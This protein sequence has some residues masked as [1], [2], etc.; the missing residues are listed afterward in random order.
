MEKDIGKITKNEITDIVIRVDNFAG[1]AGITI[2]EFAH[3]DRYTGFTKNGTKIPVDCFNEFK[4]MINSITSEDLKA[5]Q[6]AAEAEGAMTS[7]AGT[8]RTT[9][10]KARFGQKKLPSKKSAEE[11]SETESVENISETESTEGNDY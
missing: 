3:G 5:A 8:G 2:R 1:R 11:V 7:T 9:T 6:E 10:S 4:E